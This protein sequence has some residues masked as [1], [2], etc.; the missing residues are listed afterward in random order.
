MSDFYVQVDCFWSTRHHFIDIQG[1]VDKGQWWS[2]GYG[3]L[4]S[5][6]R[7]IFHNLIKQ[8]W[9][10]C[11]GPA[12]LKMCICNAASPSSWLSI[13]SSSTS[14]SQKQFQKQISEKVLSKY[15]KKFL[16]KHGFPIVL[17]NIAWPTAGF[18]FEIPYGC[19][20]VFS[21]FLPNKHRQGGFF[22]R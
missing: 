22:Y 6:T 18:I 5:A 10:T 12:S 21:P 16:K 2:G 1:K 3:C 9:I 4:V 13:F 20:R 14:R 15:S 19:L 17:S 8:F 11:A 7:G